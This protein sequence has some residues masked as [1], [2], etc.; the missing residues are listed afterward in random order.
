MMTAVCRGGCRHGWSIR[1]RVALAIVPILRDPFLLS[2]F[3]AENAGL[4]DAV[5]KDGA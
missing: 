5:N 4:N 1:N 2:H 3:Y